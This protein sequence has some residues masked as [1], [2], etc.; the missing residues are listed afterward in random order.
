MLSPASTRRAKS[1]EN[2]LKPTTRSVVSKAS[3]A[4]S[5]R[6]YLR[7]KGEQTKI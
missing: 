1:T 5:Y 2:S 7:P 6:K 4:T 3:M